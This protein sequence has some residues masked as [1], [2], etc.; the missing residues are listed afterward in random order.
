MPEQPE[1]HQQYHQ[2][3]EQ[4]STSH[5]C[6]SFNQDS[7]IPENLH[8][9]NQENLTTGNPEPEP[10]FYYEDSHVQD[11]LSHCQKSIIG[12]ILADKPIPLPIIHSSL[13]GI[14][15]NP[16]GLKISELEGKLYQIKVDKEDGLQR[17]L[18][19][20]PSII[21]NCWFVMHQWDRQVN[22]LSLDFSHVSL[23]IPFWGLPL[24][25]KSITIGK[26]LGSQL[27]TLLDVGIYDFTEKARILKVKILFNIKQPIRA[28]MY[29]GNDDDGINW[30]DFRFENLPM[31]CFV[32]GL[33]GHQGDICKSGIVL[34]EGEVNPRGAWLRTRSYGCRVIERKEKTFSS[35][36]LKSL[37][38]GQFSPIPKELLEKMAHMN[39]KKAGFNTTTTGNNNSSAY[40]ACSHTIHKSQHQHHVAITHHQS[41]SQHQQYQITPI[42]EDQKNNKRKLVAG[43]QELISSRADTQEDIIMA[44]LDNKA[45]QQA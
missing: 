4:G 14:W 40:Q 5:T 35:N 10:F 7:S 18:K 34:Q 12:K 41:H 26:E 32:C 33:I 6:H 13:L 37:S 16:V 22:A 25:C 19:G 29:I 21:R 2:F 15:C 1:F 45:S 8:D 38:G 36:P 23:W 17:I 28:E 42:K 9:T 30:V 31:L 11:S 43:V 20:S 44:G 24:H 39:L 27:G 3:Q